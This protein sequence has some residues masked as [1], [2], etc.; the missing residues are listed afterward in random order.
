[1]CFRIQVIYQHKK[2]PRFQGAETLMSRSL[3]TIQGEVGYILGFTTS[4]FF[5]V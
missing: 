1:M 2:A 5:P 4:P 3:D